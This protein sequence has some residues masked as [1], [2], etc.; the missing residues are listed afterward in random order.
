MIR[1]KIKSDTIF[2]TAMYV[3]TEFWSETLWSEMSVTLLDYT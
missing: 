2:K 3:V 1:L